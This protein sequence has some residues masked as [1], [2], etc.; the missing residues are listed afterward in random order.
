MC[1]NSISGRGYCFILVEFK[2]STYIVQI[3][4]SSNMRY[5]PIISKNVLKMSLEMLGYIQVQRL[6]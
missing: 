5:F 1:I 6:T 2:L 3:R 4:F